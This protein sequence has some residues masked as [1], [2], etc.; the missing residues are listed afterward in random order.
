[1][2]FIVYQLATGSLDAVSAHP[3]CSSE[4]QGLHKLDAPVML[5]CTEVSDFDG[6]PCET[7]GEKID[8]TG[9]RRARRYQQIPRELSCGGVNQCLK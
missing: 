1:V 4:C 3:Y 5:A 9:A 7:C 6:R 2:P 8:D